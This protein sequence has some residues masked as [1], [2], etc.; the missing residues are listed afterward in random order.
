MNKLPFVF[1]ETALSSDWTVAH[2]LGALYSGY[3]PDP[4][5]GQRHI[6]LTNEKDQIKIVVNYSVGKHVKWDLAS[7]HTSFTKDGKEYTF[8]R[9]AVE[10]SF[11][12]SYERNDEI[13][14]NK[15]VEKQIERVHESRERTKNEGGN[16][17]VPGTSIEVTVKRK[18]DLS[19]ELKKRKSIQIT[20]AG[21]GIGYSFTLKRQYRY[22]SPASLAQKKFFD[23]D[24]QLFVDTLDCD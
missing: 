6:I 15:M 5:D 23:V 8:D 2:G 21:F 19:A 1:D 3:R 9:R 7:G 12:I 13:D 22:S 10:D 24:G 11:Y 4:N 17:T 20:P 14:L 16:V 18:A